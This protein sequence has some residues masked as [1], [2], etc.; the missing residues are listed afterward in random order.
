MIIFTDFRIL[1]VDEI[2]KTRE[3]DIFKVNKNVQNH[4]N[5]Q[6]IRNSRISNFN[7]IWLNFRNRPIKS[8]DYFLQTFLEII[9]FPIVACA[10]NW[11]NVISG[12]CLRKQFF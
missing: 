6:N 12:G 10:T 5:Y 4:S 3:F 7:K 1:N 9:A 8:N 2:I 11:S